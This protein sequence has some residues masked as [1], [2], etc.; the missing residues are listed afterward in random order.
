MKKKPNIPVVLSL[1][2]AIGLVGCRSRRVVRTEQQYAAQRYEVQRD[3]MQQIATA[4]QR[5][6]H[7]QWQGATLEFEWQPPRDSSNAKVRIKLQQQQEAHQ[8][9]V[10]NALVAQRADQSR[11]EAYQVQRHQREEQR[12]QRTVS[13]YWLWGLVLVGILIMYKRQIGK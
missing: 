11:V 9:A 4:A 10:T 6:A 2:C 3:S 1:V 7:H 12:E 8:Q 13:H 5:Q